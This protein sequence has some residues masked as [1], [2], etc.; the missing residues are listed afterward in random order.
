[1]TP[2][3]NR[4]ALITGASRG[5]GRAI[6]FELAAMGYGL[7]VGSR[8]DEDLARLAPQLQ[9]AGAP[10][11][12]TV[13]CDLADRSAPERLTTAHQRA[14]GSMSALILNAGVGTAGPVA[15]VDVRRIDKTVEVNF[16]SPVLLVRAALPLL[17]AHAAGGDPRGSKIVALSSLTGVY[18]APGLA[19]YGATKAALMSLAETVNVEESGNGVTGAAIAPGY[20]AT[21]MS[22][23][24]TDQIPVEAMIP[25]E[26]VVAV[27]RALLELSRRSAVPRVAMTR[28]GTNGFSA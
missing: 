5:I 8:G 25:V 12:V 27:T 9:A 20:V 3:P 4:T 15:T 28:S 1:M 21:D 7:T 14:F 17:R 24:V 22:A 13:A 2:A 18:S 10:R 6:A 23:W 11:V 19:V 16:V 26:D